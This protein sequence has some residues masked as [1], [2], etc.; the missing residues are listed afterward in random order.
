MTLAE[1]SITIHFKNAS[2]AGSNVEAE[3]LLSLSEGKPSAASQATQ[4]GH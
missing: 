1:T 4:T 3:M 2:S